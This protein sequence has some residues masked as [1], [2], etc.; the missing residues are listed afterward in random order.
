MIVAR[1]CYHK[2]KA[3]KKSMPKRR[4]N[5]NKIY[6]QILKIFNYGKKDQFE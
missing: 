4:Q 5:Y 1:L 3:G 2:K 6:Y